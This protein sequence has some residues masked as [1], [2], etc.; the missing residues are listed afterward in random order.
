MEK[1]LR[2]A[3]ADAEEPQSLLLVALQGDLVETLCTGGGSGILGVAVTVLLLFAVFAAVSLLSRFFSAA[4][5]QAIGERL[6]HL[7]D[8]GELASASRLA[9]QQIVT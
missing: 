6:E 5:P 8:A 7:S 1:T 3:C 4:L 9:L 2:G